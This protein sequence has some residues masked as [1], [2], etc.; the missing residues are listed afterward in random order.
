MAVRVYRSGKQARQYAISMYPLPANATY[1]AAAEA[2]ILNENLYA[3]VPTERDSAVAFMN[4]YGVLKFQWGRNIRG[5][6]R[7]H[8]RKSLGL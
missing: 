2:I 5:I 3:S 8:T 6:P 1:V 7:G 4:E